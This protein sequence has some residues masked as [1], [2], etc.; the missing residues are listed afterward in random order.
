ML[1]ITYEGEIDYDSEVREGHTNDINNTSTESRVV[2]PERVTLALSW[3]I[4]G[5]VAIYVSGS[6]RDFEKFEGLEFDQS[7]QTREEVAAFG[8]EY[9][10]GLSLFGTRFPIRGSVMYEQL[11]YEFPADES[12]TSLMFGVGSGLHL[13]DGRAKL[14]FALQAGSVG[15]ISRNGLQ[16]NV[17]RVYLSVS[18][19]EVWKKKRQTRF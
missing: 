4:G 18:G 8:I 12:I 17:V 19:S 2:L 13:G 3:R 15:D 1:G 9:L 5:S 11:P 14:D 16:N 6:V 7:R 10:K